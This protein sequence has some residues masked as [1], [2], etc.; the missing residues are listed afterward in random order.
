MT[1]W[2]TKRPIE[3]TS[4]S[5]KMKHL[6]SKELEIN[7]GASNLSIVH[8]RGMIHQQNWFIITR[9][10]FYIQIW[11]FQ[12]QKTAKLMKLSQKGMIFS[13]LG[14]ISSLIFCFIAFLSNKFLTNRKN[15]ENSHYC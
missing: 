4:K 14:T 11:E 6:G 12:K 5:L 7:Y 2:M 13:V 10:E 9:W 15:D 3:A 8:V 1:D